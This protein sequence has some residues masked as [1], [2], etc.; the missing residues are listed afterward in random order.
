M[1]A[2]LIVIRHVFQQALAHH[3]L[4]QRQHELQQF[5]PHGPDEPFGNPILPGAC[6]LR[7]QRNKVERAFDKLP[8]RLKQNVV[9]RDQ[10]PQYMRLADECL[11]QLLANPVG[12]G[13][14]GNIQTKQLTMFVLDDEETKQRAPRLRK[15]VTNVQKSLCL[16]LCQSRTV[17]GFTNNVTL[18]QA[19]GNRRTVH[20]QKT[21]MINKRKDYADEEDCHG[22]YRGGRAPFT[23]FAKAD[24]PGR[25]V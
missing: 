23:C 5:F 15:L 8:N 22:E 4:A 14:F 25:A 3:G 13:T 18:R 1:R 19:S 12:S 24:E 20:I 17:A 6:D 9:I 7:A 16:R 11:N 10:E 2:V 21:L